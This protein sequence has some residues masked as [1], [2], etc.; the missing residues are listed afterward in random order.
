MT[1]VRFFIGIC[2]ICNLFG[3]S[4]CSAAEDKWP[5]TAFS[6]NEWKLT[7]DEK[8]YIYSNTLIGSKKLDGLTQKE[9]INLLGQPNYKSPDRKYITYILKYAEKN[10]YSLNSI[11]ILQI[12]FNA[13]GKVLKYFMRAD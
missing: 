13:D 10:E 12:D 3:L 1:T 11:Y 7:P 6:S 5:N 8:R 9:V 4:S 2:L